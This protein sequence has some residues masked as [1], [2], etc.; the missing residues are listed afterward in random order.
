MPP[1]SPSMHRAGVMDPPSPLRLC[2]SIGRGRSPLTQ[3]GTRPVQCAPKARSAAQLGPPAGVP[4]AGQ[5]PPSQPRGSAQPALQHPTD[6]DSSGL[7]GSLPFTA[8]AGSRPGLSPAGLLLL[9]TEPPSRVPLLRRL[10]PSRM[11]A[12]G[13]RQRQEGAGGANQPGGPSAALSPAR[14]PGRHGSSTWSCPKR[15]T[16]RREGGQE[17]PC[18]DGPWRTGLQEET[19]PW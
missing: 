11:P 8:A 7:P 2:L 9:R 10:R 4:R 1:N 15:V 14:E 16:C 19:P 13:A 6:A 12:C 17:T 18:L 3:L 5:V